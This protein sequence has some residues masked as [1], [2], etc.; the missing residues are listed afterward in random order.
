MGHE[1][2]KMGRQMDRQV[3]WMNAAAA[4]TQQQAV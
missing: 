4:A 2:K 1:A 3:Q